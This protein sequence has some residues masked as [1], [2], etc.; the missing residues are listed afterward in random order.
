MLAVGW[1]KVLIDWLLLNW[2]SGVREDLN[3]G[4]IDVKECEIKE[5]IQ[6]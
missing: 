6:N 2:V 5:K 3:N 4:Y 1:A